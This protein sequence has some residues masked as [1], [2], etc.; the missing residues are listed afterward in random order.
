[1]CE[2]FPLHQAELCVAVPDPDGPDAF[3]AHLQISHIG[4][5]QKINLSVNCKVCRS[6]IEGLEETAIFWI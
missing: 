5:K 1:M 6:H 4:H 2:G 3:S